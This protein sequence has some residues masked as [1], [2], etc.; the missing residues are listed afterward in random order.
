MKYL[1]V[2]IATDSEGID[3]YLFNGTEQ[4]MQNKVKAMCL[5]YC[6]EVEENS[7]EFS[8]GYE[9]FGY[10]TYRACAQFDDHHFLVQSFSWNNVG[11]KLPVS[12]INLFKAKKLKEEDWFSCNHEDDC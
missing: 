3:T 9:T 5:D 1:I 7:Y 10:P 6:D 2:S 8:C 12:R 4:E 11:K